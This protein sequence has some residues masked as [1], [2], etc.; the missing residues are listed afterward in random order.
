VIRRTEEAL[1]G[2]R[3]S[4]LTRRIAEGQ[5]LTPLLVADEAEAS[6]ALAREIVL[7][8][9]RYLGVGVVNLMHTI[10]PSGVVLGGAMTFGGHESPLGREFLDRVRE[11]VRRRSFPVLAERTVIDF[12]ALGADAGFIGAAGVARLEHLKC[13]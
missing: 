2:G 13:Q 10:D 4:S 11:E 7:E 3:A 12:A 8:T 9:A 6:D 1:A 5:K